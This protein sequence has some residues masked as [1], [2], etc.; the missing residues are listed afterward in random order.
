MPPRLRIRRHI[1]FVL[2]VIMYVKF[3]NSVILSETLTLL[4][5]ITFEQWALELWYFP[6][7]FLVTRPFLGTKIF[8]P[9]TLTF[10]FDLFFKNFK[11]VNYQD[12]VP[13][14]LAIFEIGRYGSIC[15]SQI[16]L[17][18]VFLFKIINYIVVLHID[19]TWGFRFCQ[20]WY[21]QSRI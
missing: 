1:V 14:T 8:Y 15:V 16:H 6:W 3:H 20:W 13:V 12:N 5:V 2:S 9:M 4:L 19:F 10:E 21:P 11:L 18:S 7:A 17:F